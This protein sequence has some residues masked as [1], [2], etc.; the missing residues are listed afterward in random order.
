MALKRYIRA[1]KLSLLKSVNDM[2][3][4]ELKYK[5]D[6][7]TPN[8][9]K[10]LREKINS[11]SDNSLEDSLHEAW[12]SAE[13]SPTDTRCLDE[14]KIQIDQQISPPVRVIPFYWKMLGVA[15]SVLL[16]LF[17]IATGYLYQKNTVLSQKEFVAFTGEGE[18][19]TI[20]L[21]DSTKV[22][23]SGG[24][25][26]SYNLSDYNSEER[27]VEFDGEA[28]FRVAKNPSS[29]FSIWA[30]GLKVSVLGTTFNLRARS[31]ETT[32]ELSLEEGSVCFH[33]LK[34]GQ[35]VVLSPNQKAVLN[36]TDG[37]VT[38]EKDQYATD[39]SAWRRGELVFRNVPLTDVLEEIEKVYQVSIVMETEVVGYQNDLFTGVLSRIN[40]NEVLEVIEHSYHLK[41]VL[42]DGTIRLTNLP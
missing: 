29:P 8:E 35:D 11:M 26:L 34:T 36:Q 42:K 3:R 21:P 22:T 5:N 18:Q 20:S 17:M 10:Q 27:R 39:A 33:A 9:L 28:Y 40:I 41:A 13:A 6:R 38:V 37:T 2:D 1:K 14:L 32:A 24:S 7:L 19:V 12:E 16:P 15:A 31:V 25:R 4:L 30:K 23:L